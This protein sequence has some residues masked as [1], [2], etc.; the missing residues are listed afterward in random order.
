MT[1][2]IATFLQAAETLLATF[3]AIDVRAVVR[4]DTRELVALVG[5]LVPTDPLIEQWEARRNLAFIRTVVPIHDLE[6]FL[7]GL[8]EGQI[9]LREMTVTS[10][11]QNFNLDNSGSCPSALSR[12]LAR[13]Q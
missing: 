3:E 10:A 8:K 13:K 2:A 11:F 7:P 6:E 9:R 5:C 12:N 4:T 1:D